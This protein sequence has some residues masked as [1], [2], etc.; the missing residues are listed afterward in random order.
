MNDSGPLIVPI[1]VQAMVV[2]TA[3]MNFIRA[4]MDYRQLAN[5]MS[6]SPAPFQNDAGSGFAADP[7]NRGDYLMVPRLQ[8]P[9]PRQPK[10]KATLPFPSLPNPRSCVLAYRS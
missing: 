6:P 9:R 7:A 3:N 5:F 8:A 1:E 10:H 4:A 2:N